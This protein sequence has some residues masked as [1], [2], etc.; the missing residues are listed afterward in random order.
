MMLTFIL[1]L[2]LL[3]PCTGFFSSQRAVLINR[4]DPLF[5]I[6][7]LGR[8]RKKKPL[9]IQERISVGIKIPEGDVEMITTDS[10]GKVV[11]I[12]VTMAEVL[13]DG[14]SILVGMPGKHSQGKTDA[15]HR[16]VVDSLFATMAKEHL[17]QHA[18]RSIF[19]A[20]YLP[21]QGFVN[22]VSTKSL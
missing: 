17:P 7:F 15:Y 11:T 20:I 1:L 13:G 2:S 8:F 19:L 3:H 10:G 18:H 12:P 16:F 6:P 21:P 9:V 22:L 5:G 14:T 4:V